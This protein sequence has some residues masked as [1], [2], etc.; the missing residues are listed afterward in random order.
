MGNQLRF[1]SS[2]LP[3]IV[4]VFYGAWALAADTPQSMTGLLPPAGQVCPQGSW[5][6]GFDN[7]SNILCSETCGNRVLNDGEACDDGNTASGDGCSAMCQSETPTTVRREE[8]V[9]PELPPVP[10]AS[11]AGTV[12]A[13]AQPVISKIKPSNIVFGSREVTVAIS[14]TGFTSETTVLFDGTSY[15]P[16]VNQAGTELKVTLAT[17]DLAMGRYPITISNGSGM[18]ITKKKGLTVF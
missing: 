16:S 17:R 1:S 12:S 6:I 7:E 13:L 8:I 5:V 11:T 3:A 15:T 2:F 10:P 18:E 9:A 14:G 4:M